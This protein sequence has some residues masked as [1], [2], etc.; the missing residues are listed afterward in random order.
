MNNDTTASP[1]FMK[2]LELSKV[3]YQDAVKPILDEHYS[4]LRYSAAHI[5]QDSDVL[6]FD[7]EQSMDHGWGPRL[8]LFVSKGD[9]DRSATDLINVLGQHL[10]FDILGFP[11]NF[12]RH[13][14]GTL[15]MVYTKIR[16]LD[17][18]VQVV[19]V[20]DFFASYLGFDPQID[21]DIID[22]LVV[23]GQILRSVISGEVFHDGLGKL[24][25]IR[26]KLDYY[27]HDI[28]LYLLAN[29]WRRIDQEIPF[30]GRCGQVNDEVGSQIVASRQ[31]QD[32]M[33][34][35]FLME[36]R[37]APYIKWFGSA[38]SHLACSNDL[39][40]IFIQAF[41]ARNWKERQKHL[42]SAYEY[43]AQMHNE[44]AITEFIENKVSSFHNRPFLIIQAEDF[45]D[46]IY[47]Q[48]RDEKIK[49]LPKWLGSV[50]QYSDST[51][52]LAYSD[53]LRKLRVMY[54]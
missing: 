9:Y 27:P 8:K 35:C 13:E 50:N 1:P 51:D 42:V 25:K 53:M 11:I 14:D 21:M 26:N 17:H 2:G 31:I 7:T 28:W 20:E 38:F 22:W 10:P 52:V 40:P 19:T 6:G 15:K 46:A 5:G 23:P 54:E 44:L 32:L 33:N 4:G 43:V 48:I 3:L 16:P 18:G 12:G 47:K 34:L 24:E 37:Y 30:M 45:A 29:Q 49:S 39:I 41:D 36:K